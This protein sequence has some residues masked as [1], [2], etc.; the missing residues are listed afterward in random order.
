[1]KRDKLRKKRHS[2][3]VFITGSVYFYRVICK[4]SQR[5]LNYK[6]EM[7]DFEAKS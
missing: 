2:F 7:Y 3:K 5:V 6:F 4:T 1:M